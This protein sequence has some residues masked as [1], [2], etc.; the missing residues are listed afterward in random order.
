MVKARNRRL[1]LGVTGASG[2]IYAQRLLDAL[3]ESSWEIHVILSKY[4]PAVISEELPGGLQLPA[5]ATL[6][7]PKSMNLPFASGSSVADAMVIAPC[8]MGTLARIVHG[9]SEDALLRAADVTLKERR[10]LILAPRET[11]LSLIHARNLVSALEVGAT[12]IP[13]CPSFYTR[14]ESIPQLVDTVIARILDHLGVA[15]DLAPR[16]G[17]DANDIDE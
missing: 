1:A 12:V 3:A 8:S 17:D 2:A 9:T 7:S 11:P 15:N 4:A 10:P 6:H 5:N 14:P 13:A 16:W